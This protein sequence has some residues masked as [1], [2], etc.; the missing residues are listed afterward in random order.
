M[1]KTYLR[2]TG[3]EWTD[4]DIDK[5]R[6]LAEGDTPTGVIGLKLG[7]SKSAVYTKASE[8]NISLA[9]PNRSP[10]GWSKKR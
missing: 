5:L 1:P 6:E 9:P 4:E 7:R 3:K 10:Y 8:E 2:N